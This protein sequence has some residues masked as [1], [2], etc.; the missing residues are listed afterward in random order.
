MMVTVI[1][2]LQIPLG[3]PENMHEILMRMLDTKS[4]R[5]GQYDEDLTESA[6]S[7]PSWAAPELSFIVSA[8]TVNCVVSSHV[9]LIIPP[10]IAHYS[11]YHRRI[12]HYCRHDIS[13]CHHQHRIRTAS[14]VT[15]SHLETPAYGDADAHWHLYCHNSYRCPLTLSV[16]PAGKWPLIGDIE[17]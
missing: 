17:W 7:P 11:H 4:D 10:Y 1:R 12:R 15:S 14:A 6:R 5:R 3:G 9:I 2:A 16:C 13:Q 8:K